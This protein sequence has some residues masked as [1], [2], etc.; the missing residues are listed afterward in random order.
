MTQG[1][2][3]KIAAFA[4]KQAPYLIA[5]V[6]PEGQPHITAAG[7][8]AI[9]EAGSAEI[10]DWFCDTTVS[11]LHSNPRISV[12]IWDRIID[13]G[14]QLLGEAEKVEDMAIMNGFSPELDEKAHLPQVERKLVV[15]IRKIFDFSHRG[16]SDREQ[17]P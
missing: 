15:R 3:Q 11:N 4:E 14:Y 10:T 8:L 13:V 7:K 17:L 1:T 12:I 16:Q 9:S 5:T 6:D 2:L